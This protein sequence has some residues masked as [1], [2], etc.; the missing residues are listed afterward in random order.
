MKR[1]PLTQGEVCHLKHRLAVVWSFND[2]LA[3]LR[4]TTS[5]GGSPEGRI[6]RGCKDGAI[7]TCRALAERFGITMTSKN[8][9]QL[10]ACT[11]TFRTL[12][13]GCHSNATPEEVDALWEVLIAANRAVC[14][15]EDKLIDHRV[16]EPTLQRAIFLITSIANRKMA[17]ANLSF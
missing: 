8:W 12:V 10:V 15:L 14:H 7:A 9:R 2:V 1:G 17:E 3:D 11:P 6:Y 16:D 13:T 5:L 4:F